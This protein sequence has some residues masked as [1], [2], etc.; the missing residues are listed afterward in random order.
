MTAYD[1]T[2]RVMNECING[3]MLPHSC[4][5]RLPISVAK[6]RNFIPKHRQNTVTSANLSLM[7]MSVK[8]HGFRKNLRYDLI[9]HRYDDD[10]D[11]L[12]SEMQCAQR[13]ILDQM[14]RNKLSYVATLIPNR[15]SVVLSHDDHSTDLR[16]LYDTAVS[17]HSC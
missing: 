14:S 8:C 2:V 13:M 5:V 1:H 6:S 3:M 10:F 7:R 9:R 15:R 4:F 12:H 11:S 16:S 17:R